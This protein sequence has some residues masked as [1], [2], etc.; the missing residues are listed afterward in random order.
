RGNTIQQLVA[1]RTK[2]N[3]ILLLSLDAILIT[4]VILVFRNVKKEVQLAQNKADFVSNVSHEIRTPLALI[5]MFAETLEMNRV[6]TEAKK[7]E[8]YNIISKEA[9]RLSGIVNKILN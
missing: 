7:H 2:T 8:Y 4:A 6:N 1:E 3:L 9:Q 5:S